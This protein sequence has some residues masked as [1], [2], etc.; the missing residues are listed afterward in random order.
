MNK[1]THINIGGLPFIMNEDAYIFLQQYFDSITAHFQLS[2]GSEEIVA[3]I[4]ARIAELLNEKKGARQIV[5][6]EDV[7]FAINIM[8]RPE[9]FGADPIEETKESNTGNRKDTGFNPGKR[10]YKN[11]DD[12][13]VAGVCSG[14]SIYLGIKDPVWM[15]LLFGL[16]AVVGGGSGIPIYFILM[17]ILKDAKTPKEKLEMKGDPINLESLVNTMGTE[18][19]NLGEQ[20]KDFGKKNADGSTTQASELGTSLQEGFSVVGQNLES[21]F[22]SV[23]RAL[24]PIIYIL[25]GVIIFALIILWS[26][27]LFSAFQSGETIRMFL[28]AS[29]WE[30]MFAIFSIL[31]LVLLPIM[32]IG[33]SV[34]QTFFRVSIKPI[35]YGA[36][37]GLWTLNIVGMTFLAKNISKSYRSEASVEIPFQLKE[38]VTGTYVVAP[39]SLDGQNRRS[40]EVGDLSLERDA[41]TLEFLD[42]EVGRSE[43][44]KIEFI[45]QKSS[46]GE[47]DEQAEAFAKA[48]N[49]EIVQQGDTLMVPDFQQVIKGQKFSNQ[50]VELKILIPNGKQLKFAEEIGNLKFIT[51]VGGEFISSYKLEGKCY[52]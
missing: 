15:R 18:F 3:D 30:S 42:I 40:I 44:D 48:I 33:L 20:F 49:Y 19:K 2:E 24:R 9:D 13:I 26:T 1:V 21:F 5:E 39:L 41:I 17:F 7:Q 28:P 46:S 31:L 52:K 38:A 23:A 22:R 6:I 43:S 50:R 47:S 32:S 37:W 34:T 45:V 27:I 36:I 16:L 4:E 8:G 51:D 11:P 12:K 35:W 14:L 10:L 25:G 29:T